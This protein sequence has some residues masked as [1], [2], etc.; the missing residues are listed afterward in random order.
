MRPSA[1]LRP[2]AARA[3]AAGKLR[4]ATSSDDFSPHR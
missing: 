4:S 3:A 1:T 2:A